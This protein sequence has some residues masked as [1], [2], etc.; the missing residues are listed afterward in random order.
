MRG[1]GIVEAKMERVVRFYDPHRQKPVALRLAD[2]PSLFSEGS[3][4]GAFVAPNAPAA[5][6][7]S[8]LG[9]LMRFLQMPW[10]FMA[11]ASAAGSR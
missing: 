9:E 2:I 6:A 7:G 3:D 1:T 10:P 8:R 4:A 5:A 11:P